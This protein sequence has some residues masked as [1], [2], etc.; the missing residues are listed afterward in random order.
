MRLPSFRALKCFEVAA[1]NGTL[2]AA[3]REMNITPGAVSRQ[4]T[5]LEEH[6]GIE[7]MQRHSKGL[8]LTEQGRALAIHLSGAFED[9]RQ[10]LQEAIRDT[11]NMTV[12]LNV[13]PTFAIQWLMPRIGDF[14][15]IAPQVDLRVRPSLQ[16]D[17]GDGFDRE[18]INVAITIGAPSDPAITW[19]FLFHRRF[20]PVCSPKTA[21]AVLPID[22]KT[23]RDAR[24]FYSD[25]HISQWQLWLRA[26]GAKEL[27]LANIGIRFENSSLAY[28]AAREGLGFA[29]GQPTLLRADLESGRLVAPFPERVEDEKPYVVAC[30]SRD[31]DQPQIRQFMDWI[32]AVASQSE[33]EPRSI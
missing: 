25:R 14:H 1:R 27:D 18:E 22:L 26:V 12:T 11:D 13:F 31:K 20:T 16:G 28:Q 7:L 8:T 9:I 2:T 30:R 15:A 3:A 21:N 17:K 33:K 10:A 24:I 32:T 29:I 6:L 23:L 19:R 5:S 4:I